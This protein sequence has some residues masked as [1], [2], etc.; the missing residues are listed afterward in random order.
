MVSERDLTPGKKRGYVR[1]R[2]TIAGWA[3]LSQV[4][5][6]KLPASMLANLKPADDARSQEFVLDL[7]AATRMD[8]WGPKIVEGRQQKV[9]WK[10]ICHRTG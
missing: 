10:E 1:L 8:Q 3:V 6:E 4:P 2:M 9:K 5:G 7:G